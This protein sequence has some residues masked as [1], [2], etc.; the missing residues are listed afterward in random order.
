VPS[1]Q[2]ASDFALF[3]LSQTLADC[4]AE[5]LQ[6]IQ[7]W[8]FR[9]GPSWP[10]SSQSEFNLIAQARITAHLKKSNQ[11]VNEWHEQFDKLVWSRC[12]K[13]CRLRAIGSADSELVQSLHDLCWG[14]ISAKADKYHGKSKASTWLTVV[15]DNTIKDYFK[16]NDN[17]ARLAPMSSIASEECR[18][19]ADPAGIQCP[20]RCTRPAGASP[21]DEAKNL[22]Q[23]EWDWGQKWNV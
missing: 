10:A 6:T 19:M 14:K 1:K 22:K 9:H 21:R 3:R 5:E 15:C 4:P 13:A 7:G 16:V 12:H 17:R 18:E 8:Y 23:R 11:I 2:Y 20:E